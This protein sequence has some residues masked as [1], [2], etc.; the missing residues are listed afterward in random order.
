[1]VTTSGLTA[2]LGVPSA[3]CVGVDMCLSASLYPVCVCVWR[4]AGG[5]WCVL[6][7]AI[8]RHTSTRT[9]TRTSRRTHARTHTPM[10]HRCGANS[11][12]SFL[13][14]KNDRVQVRARAQREHLKHRAQQ[15][16][17]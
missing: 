9:R 15:Q 4:L 11:M 3:L 5:G 1:M 2:L 13:G 6:C 17:S 10:T 16:K 8:A 7:V 14:A 12:Q